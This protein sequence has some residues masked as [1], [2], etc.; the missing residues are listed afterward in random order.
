MGGQHLLLD[1]TNRQH[2]A[3]QR[4]LSGHADRRLDRPPAEQ[5]DQRRRHGDAGRRAVL[6]HG[7]RGHV[8]VETTLLEGVGGETQVVCVGADVREG[9]LRRFLHHVAQL[10]GDGQPRL[11]GHR[12]RLD[13]QHVATGAGNGQAGGHAGHSR[14]IR[15]LQEEPRAAEIGADVVAVDADRRL[16]VARRQTGGGLAQHLAELALELTHTRLTR[17]VGHHGLDGVVGQGDLLGAQTVALELT[18]EQVVAR[19]CELLVLCVAIE[20]DDLHAVQQ[21]TGDGVGHVRGRDEQHLGQV[22]LDLEVVV[23]EGVILGRVEDFEERG[24]GVASP[25]GAQL[26]DL[27]EKEDRVHRSGLLESAGDTTGHGPDVGAAV[28]ADL[29]LVADAAQRDASELAPERA[30]HRLAERRLAHARRTHE[31]EDRPCTA[32]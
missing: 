25:V 4:D 27:V 13:E 5:A 23:A 12:R 7:A 32:L 9:D 1:A 3:L 14:A 18:P 11:T 28:A 6:G 17:V 31:G 20:A 26:V 29:G 10:T 19:D 30:G 22:E 2:P 15:R 24:R 8:H 16:G 21:R